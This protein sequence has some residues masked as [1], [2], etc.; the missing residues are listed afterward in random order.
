L[1]INKET[2]KGGRRKKTTEDSIKGKI[3]Y[4]QSTVTPVKAGVLL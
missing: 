2:S 1:A 4:K 3:V